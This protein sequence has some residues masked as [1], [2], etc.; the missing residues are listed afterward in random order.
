MWLRDE[1]GLIGTDGSA[2]EQIVDL[3]P[4]ADDIHIDGAHHFMQQDKPVEIACYIKEFIEG[5]DG[6]GSTTCNF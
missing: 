2:H 4:Q 1:G 6:G 5:I 3:L